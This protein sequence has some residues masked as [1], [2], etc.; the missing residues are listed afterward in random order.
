MSRLTTGD[1]ALD[2]HTMDMNIPDTLEKLDF[3]Y[4]HYKGDSERVASV[5]SSFD[6]QKDWSYRYFLSMKNGT[7]DPRKQIASAISKVYQDIIGKPDLRRRCF[8]LECTEEEL[9]RMQEEKDL[10]ARAEI[11]LGVR[12]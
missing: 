8:W 4:K 10:R 3:I 12:Q 7:M 9:G 5:V 11:Q 6:D 1:A 2:L